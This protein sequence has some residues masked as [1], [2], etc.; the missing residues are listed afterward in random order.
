ML[1]LTDGQRV[2][3]DCTTR[4]E[5]SQRQRSL[6]QL[7]DE[8]CAAV[9]WRYWVLGSVDP[10]YRRNVAW[11]SGYRHPRYQGGGVLADALQEAFAEPT[12]LARGVG[13]LGDPLLVLPAVFHALWSGRL[14][15]DLG[16]AMH[17]QMPVWAP[18]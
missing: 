1:R 14:V 9:G 3:A 13:G 8:L 16:A 17:E 7:M 18:R 5:L 15:A 10:I 2:L 12:P 6:G 11:L 4:T